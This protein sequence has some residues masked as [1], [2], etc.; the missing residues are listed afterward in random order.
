V[1]V[2]CGLTKPPRFRMFPSLTVRVPLSAFSE[3]LMMVR[4][5]LSDLF[6]YILAGRQAG[7]QAGAESMPTHGTHRI[8]NGD[9][10]EDGVWIV[11]GKNGFEIPESRYRAN[12]YQPPVE[13]LP[14]GAP[15]GCMADRPC[16]RHAGNPGTG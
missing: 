11:D 8:K 10:I 5:S 6:G 7:R 16:T 12:N 13:D 4:I 14:W 2:L 1:A 3:N 9:G 15:L